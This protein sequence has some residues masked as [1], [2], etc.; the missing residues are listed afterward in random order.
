MIDE[1]LVEICRSLEHRNHRVA[2]ISSLSLPF[3]CG[4]LAYPSESNEQIQYTRWYS[5]YVRHDGPISH[6]FTPEI[7]YRLRGELLHFYTTF[8]AIPANGSALQQRIPIQF[9]EGTELL[10]EPTGE[11][12]EMM[13]RLANPHMELRG[14][15]CEPSVF[16]ICPATFCA[17]IVTGAQNWLD[18]LDEDQRAS[19]AKRF[20]I[21]RANGRPDPVPDPFIVSQA[22]TRPKR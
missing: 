8:L 6:F 22:R 4:S 15:G 9:S 21:Y 14:V 10:N 13:R 18:S 17:E 5:E 1:L 12:A 3:M 2:L 20:T 11:H 19:L 7:A 16:M